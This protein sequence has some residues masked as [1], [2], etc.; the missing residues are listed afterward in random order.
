MTELNV[1]FGYRDVQLEADS[2]GS[3]EDEAS[4][5]SEE[6]NNA[7]GEENHNKKANKQKAQLRQAYQ[8]V[9]IDLGIGAHANVEK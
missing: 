1:H 8:V 5:A 3:D 9:E 4:S 7:A 6:E 2:E